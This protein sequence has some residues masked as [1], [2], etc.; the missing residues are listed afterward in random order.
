MFDLKRARAETP[1]C[2]NVMHFNNAGSSLVPQVVLDAMVD[3]LRLEAMIGGYEAAGKTAALETVYDRIGDFINCHRDEV[4]LIENATR[5]W[6]MAFYGIPFQAGDRILTSHAS[7]ASNYIA[8]LQ[9]KKRY[10]VE[11]TA[12][13]NDEHGQISIEALKKLIDDRVK[14]IALTHIPTNGGL[15]NPAEAV[16]KVAKEAGVL[17]LLDACQ[18]V[19]QL[20]L[21]VEAIGCDML[22]ATGRKF[23]RGPRGTGFLYVRQSVLDKLEPP[24]LDLH[25]AKWT[26]RDSYELVPNA[27]RF[28]NWERNFAGIVGLET[29]VSYALDWGMDNIW[30]RIQHL[31]NQLRQQLSTIPQVTVRDLGVVKGGIVTFTV[32]GVAAETIKEG[33]A[34]QKI[35]V[36]TSTVFSTRLD[37]EARN[38]DMLVRA[39]VHYYNS[40]EEIVRFCEAIEGLGR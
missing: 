36:T 19:G 35:N 28:E 4:A 7:Y 20:P 12:V 1:G 9:A 16:G 37:M 33:L 31:G 10:G 39:S 13:P 29:A 8:F 2:D 5:A 25:A 11:I 26:A 34:T 27:K 22:S 17:F 24:M 18:S 32:D 21:D 30:Q 6:D 40:E 14:L 38:L 3:Y 23:L 15:V